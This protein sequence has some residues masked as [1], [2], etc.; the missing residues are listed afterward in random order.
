MDGSLRV[1]GDVVTPERYLGLWRTAIAQPLMPEQFAERHAVCAYVELGGRFEGLRGRRASWSSSPFETF[2]HFE[3]AYLERIDY[4]D[5]NERFRVEFD[6]RQT[7]AARDAFY[8]ESFLSY[9]NQLEE[10]RSSIAL[11]PFVPSHT[12]LP[13]MPPAQTDFFTVMEENP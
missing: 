8:L 12:S 3:A 9:A 11:K 2:D 10:S 4:M 7:H 6:L 1:D 5:D 13:A